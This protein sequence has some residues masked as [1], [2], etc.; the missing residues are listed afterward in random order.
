MKYLYIIICLLFSGIASTQVTTGKG[1]TF[2]EGFLLTQSQV[3]E[4][5]NVRNTPYLYGDWMPAK[6]ELLSG[7]ELDKPTEVIL[8]IVNDKI[9]VE[10]DSDKI[11]EV[12]PKDISRLKIIDNS[13][14]RNFISRRIKEVENKHEVGNRMY[15]LL[16]EHDE[17][18]IF[19]R[20]TKTFASEASKNTYAG[21]NN[22][23]YD[24]KDKIT[25]FLKFKQQE[26][27]AVNLNRKTMIELF[28]RKEK[29]IKRFIKE[30]KIDLKK[31]EDLNLLLTQLLSD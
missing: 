10:L 15:E 27:K 6:I 3:Q 26:F 22:A 12:T 30:E 28:P 4:N 23:S 2:Y 1:N 9:F 29:W 19:R 8:D 7:N 25:Y 13:G 16:F 21:Q 17:L 24:Y 31:S 5:K 11:F 20:N 14:D 18:L